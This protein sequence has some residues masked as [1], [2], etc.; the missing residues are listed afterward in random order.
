MRRWL[1]SPF[2]PPSTLPDSPAS[3]SCRWDD[4]EARPVVDTWRIVAKLLKQQ[5][6]GVDR[7]IH[8]PVCRRG[9][10]SVLG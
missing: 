6:E 9:S 4:Q 10:A 5:L 3:L 8:K 7:R 2:V 1:S